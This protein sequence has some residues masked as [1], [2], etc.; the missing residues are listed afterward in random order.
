M[1]REDLGILR[2]VLEREERDRKEQ[3]DFEEGE[4]NASRGTVI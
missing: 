2:E 1:C 4:Q 3:E